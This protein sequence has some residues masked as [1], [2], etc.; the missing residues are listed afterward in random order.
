MNNIRV[1][2]RNATLQD[3]N[4]DLLRELLNTKEISWDGENYSDEYFKRLIRDKE[5]AVFLVAEF[6]SEIVGIIFGEYSNKEDWAELGGVAILENYRKQGIGFQLIDKFEKIIFTKNIS[7]IYLSAHVNT[8]A[9]YIHKL[10]YERG[11]TFIDF[12]KKLV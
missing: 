5:N 4:S 8:L 9:K 3:M 2:I 12:R 7:F 6:E 1:R 11:E 10:G